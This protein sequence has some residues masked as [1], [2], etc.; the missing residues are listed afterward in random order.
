MTPIYKYECKCEFCDSEADVILDGLHQLCWKH[1]EKAMQDGY[2]Y[3]SA[4]TLINP[5][6][7]SDQTS[8][9]EQRS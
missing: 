5:P 6:S 8:T 1:Y 3:T 2:Q 4:R 9:Q 7:S